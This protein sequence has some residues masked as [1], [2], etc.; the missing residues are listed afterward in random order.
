MVATSTWAATQGRKALNITWD[1]GPGAEESTAALQKQCRVKASAEQHVQ[2]QRFLVVR[3]SGDPMGTL[4]DLRQISAAIDRDEPLNH[5]MS[6]SD[7]VNREMSQIQMQTALLSGPAA[8]ALIMASVG[9]YGVMAYV[10]TQ[11]TQEIGV[12]MALGAQKRQVLGMVLKRGMTLTLLGTIAG[13][14]AAFA[15]VRLM[16][17]LL[18][19]ISPTDVSVMAGGAILLILVALAACLVPAFRAASIDPIEALR[20]E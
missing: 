20:G 12:R 11:R 18:F 19:G 7:L 9:I 13:I 15:V 17:S 5:V 2:W 10:V 4:K 3:T 1:K 16:T 6:M 8:L 14:S